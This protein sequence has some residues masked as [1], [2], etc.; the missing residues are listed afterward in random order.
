MV[1]HINQAQ[2]IGCTPLRGCLELPVYELKIGFQRQLFTVLIG[3]IPVWIPAAKVG[4]EAE[5]RLIMAFDFLKASILSD[6]LL[7]CDEL[8]HFWESV[9][10]WMTR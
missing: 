2:H 3:G 5:C 10:L 6:Q 9:M 7:G 4:Q 1:F 8:Q